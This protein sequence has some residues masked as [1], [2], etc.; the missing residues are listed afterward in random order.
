MDKKYASV[1][2]YSRIK[3]IEKVNDEFALCKIYIQ[4]V[5]KNRNYSYMSKE[6]VEK[7]L[8]TLN[9]VPVVGHLIPKFDKE[10]NTDGYYMG[11]HDYE[12]TDDLCFKSLTVP[13]G[14]V[15]EDSFDFETINEFGKDELYL[16]A[17]AFLWIGR[18]PELLSA[19][20]DENTWFNQSMEL[21]VSEYRP[22]EED[23]NYTEILA[24][25]YSALCL[26]GL[27]DNPSENTEPCFIS[28]QVKP[29]DYSFNKSEFASAMS[30]LQISLHS[31]LQKEGGEEDLILTEEKI[32]TILAEF[33][34][35][36][37]QL[38][39]EITE[40]MDEAAFR[41][42]IEAMTPAKTPAE[43]YAV[44][45]KQRREALENALDPVVVRNGEGTV[46]SETRYWTVDF[47]DHH[48]YVERYFWSSDEI[49]EDYGRF[50]Y[51][52]TEDD[53]GLVATI[54]SEFELM[55]LQ[56]LTV[57]ENKKLEQSRNAFEVL[58]GEFED[59]KK[60]YTVKDEEVEQL[61]QFKNER[62]DADHKAAIDE[63]LEAFADL[64]ENAEF[65][66][67]I[68]DDGAY[69]FEN[70]EDLEKEC[71]VIRGKAA[72]VK[73]SKASKKPE[74]KIPLGEGG[75]LTKSRYGDLFSRY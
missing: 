19:I 47:D 33:N 4:S 46:I 67:L 23:S 8:P 16:T 44:T 53:S 62:L 36:R 45:Y 71:F 70:P 73:F 2:C 28:A 49:N 37:D 65:A 26:L 15:V 21:T 31:A 34:L 35:K 25:N 39:F 41:T 20:Y 17:K 59:Y 27:S 24:W 10:G 63:V 74:I 9:Y 75:E 61:R 38:T 60:D 51:S 18:Y 11:G 42:A 68:K 52:M 13:F 72:P 22:L 14:V 6:N 5:G 1:Q 48:V 54:E 30:E 69:G 40:D 43:S 64:R 56:W 32:N 55:I 58:K 29:E 3:P 50:K 57:E 7:A 66:E 12:I